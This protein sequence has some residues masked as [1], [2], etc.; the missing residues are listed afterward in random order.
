MNVRLNLANRFW[1]NVVYDFLV[2]EFLNQREYHCELTYQD[3]KK[4]FHD[5]QVLLLKKNHFWTRLLNE[6][7]TTLDFNQDK[8]HHKHQFGIGSALLPLIEIP[9]NSLRLIIHVMQ[10][11]IK[12]RVKP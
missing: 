5:A 1:L 2:E 4:L 11:L 12:P 3:Q 9:I 8:K 7:Q 10:M 6:F